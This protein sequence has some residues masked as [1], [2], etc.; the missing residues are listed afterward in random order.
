MAMN[1]TSES[2]ET[3]I[4]ESSAV[5]AVPTAA[6][7]EEVQRLSEDDLSTSLL[8][9]N[10]GKG[11]LDHEETNN[12]LLTARGHRHCLF[13]CRPEGAERQADQVH[14]VGRRVQGLRGLPSLSGSCPAIV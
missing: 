11:V 8:P 13:A 6:A 14:P 12:L 4:N 7:E 1:R 3:G 5:P 10:L 2:A 9:F